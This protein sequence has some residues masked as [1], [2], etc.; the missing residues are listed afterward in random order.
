[1]TDAEAQDQK[2][3]KVPDGV[4]VIVM[5][6]GRVMASASDFDLSMP[7]GF[8]LRDIQTSRAT[9]R[10]WQNAFDATCHPHVASAI[11]SATRVSDVA[12]QLMFHHGWSEQVI[13]H[14]HEDDADD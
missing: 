8:T 3:V 13:L 5:F 9:R 7:V 14:G 1:M 6:N 11:T 4:T 12:R 2:P 10:A